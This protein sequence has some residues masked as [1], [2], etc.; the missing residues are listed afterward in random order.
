MA[1]QFMATCSTP[2]S[3]DMYTGHM[4]LFKKVKIPS[5]L[6]R[7]EARVPVIE[8]TRF[9]FRLPRDHGAGASGPGEGRFVLSDRRAVPQGWVWLW[10][11]GPRSVE[12]S[13]G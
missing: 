6:Y 13:A 11:A 2:V 8:T 7:R 10:P 3:R 5:C 12:K 4:S 1:F 9:R